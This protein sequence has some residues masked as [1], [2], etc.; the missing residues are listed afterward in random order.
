MIK[1]E[2][3]C[4]GCAECIGCWRKARFHDVH[5]CDGCGDYIDVETDEVFYLQTG[6]EFC[7]DCALDLVFENHLREEVTR[8]AAE[9]MMKAI[10]LC[11]VDVVDVYEFFRIPFTEREFD[12]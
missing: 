11:P 5:Y 8:E 7:T 1:T 12:V 4:V 10:G 9:D 6:E 3:L 2:S